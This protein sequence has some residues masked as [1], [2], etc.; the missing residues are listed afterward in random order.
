MGHIK[1]DNLNDEQLQQEFCHRYEIIRKTG[2][3]LNVLG[4]EMRERSLIPE[5]VRIYYPN[6]W[7]HGERIQT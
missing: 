3:R 5:Y 4:A 2:E 7:N 1:I 6:I